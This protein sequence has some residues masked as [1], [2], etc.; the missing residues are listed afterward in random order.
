MEV[1][2]F[3]HTH[4]QRDRLPETFLPVPYVAYEA[5]VAS[6][7]THDRLD[8]VIAIGP[9]PEDK[10]APVAQLPRYSIVLDVQD[11][12]NLGSIIRTAVGLGF[13]RV[14]LS[15]KCP[16]PFNPIALRTSAGAV[17][18]MRYGNEVEAFKVCQLICLILFRMHIFV[19]AF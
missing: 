1:F 2:P 10:Y 3:S 12:T 11:P 18:A 9:Y 16:S 17:F 8:P 19:A 15:D 4:N 7:M 14:F 13:G 6:L 5:M